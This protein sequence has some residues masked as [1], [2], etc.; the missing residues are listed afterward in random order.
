MFFFLLIQDNKLAIISLRG[1][2][3]RD[4]AHEEK[5]MFLIHVRGEMYEIHT[6]SQEERSTWMTLIWDAIEQ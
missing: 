1:L 3:V 4:V 5:A 6:A 2:I